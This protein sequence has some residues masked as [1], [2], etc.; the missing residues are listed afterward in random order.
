MGLFSV[1]LCGRGGGRLIDLDP[2]FLPSFLYP[3]AHVYT[4]TCTTE[5]MRPLITRGLEWARVP[6]A[7]AVTVDGVSLIYCND[8]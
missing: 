2:S 7:Y 4:H 8:L 6:S 1:L 3:P 5:R